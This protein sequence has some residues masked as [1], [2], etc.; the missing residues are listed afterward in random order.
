MAYTKI[1]PLRAS[2]KKAVD[3]TLNKDKTD[4]S[5][6][7]DYA[8]DSSKNMDEHIVFETAINC[9]V[10]TAYQDMMHTKKAYYKTGGVL[11]YN[12]IQSFSPNEV[13]AQ[14]AHAIG[15]EFATKCFGSKYEVIVSTHL[16]KHHYHNH[17]VMNSVSFMDGSKYE[18]SFKDYFVDIRGYSD[19]IYKAYN[20]SVISPAI[21]NKSLTYIEWLSLYKGKTTWQSIIKEDIDVA[22]K[23]SYTF[24]E[25]LVYMEHIGYQ[26]KHGKYIAFRPYGKERFSRGYKLG[27]G[28]SEDKLRARIDGKDFNYVPEYSPPPKSIYQPYIK[29]HVISD[30]ERNYWRWIYQMDL[31]KKRKAPPKMTKYLK[32]ELLKLER[33]KEQQTFLRTHN[34]NTASEF[35]DYIAGVD[36]AISQLNN[37]LKEFTIPLKDNKS[38]Y[39][40]LADMTK[41]K[42]VHELYLEGYTMMESENKLYLKAIE[43]LG[44]ND[45]ATPEDINA[46]QE[47]KA[48]VH[49]QIADI[50]RDI[51][52]FR[53]ERKTCENIISTMEHMKEKQRMIENKKLQ[54]KQS[55]ERGD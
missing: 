46:L 22:V 23:N 14:M 51:R 38:L 41:Y 9:M 2:L 30:L 10:D 31:V 33:Y 44:K 54:R 3:Y 49:D 12:I 25:F 32:G 35:F 43:V 47:E 26:V 19:S 4:L 1:V 50:K 20:L 40:A 5:N 21:E 27:Q 11:G 29:R 36:N 24:G 18:N 48:N 17:I 7:M 52:Y 28:Y 55:K 37:K 39:T 8:K 34:L 15:V 13:T 42:K 16:N 45:I 53:K 6:A